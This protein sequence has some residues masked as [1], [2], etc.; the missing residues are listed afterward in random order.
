M[1]VVNMV[2]H[3]SEKYTLKDKKINKSLK[4]R[5]KLGVAKGSTSKISASIRCII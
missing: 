5:Y 2:T 1:N 4:K 3:M